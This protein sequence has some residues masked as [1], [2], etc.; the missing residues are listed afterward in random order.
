MPTGA[1]AICVEE[2]GTE[3]VMMKVPGSGGVKPALPQAAETHSSQPTEAMV[4]LVLQP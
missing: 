1:S 3:S 2:R 4:E